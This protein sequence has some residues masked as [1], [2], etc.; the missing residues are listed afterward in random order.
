MLLKNG[1]LVILLSQKSLFCNELKIR[2][3][4]SFN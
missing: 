2:V 4:N 3:L 1:L